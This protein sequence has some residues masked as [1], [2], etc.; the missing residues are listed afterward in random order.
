MDEK[1]HTLSNLIVTKEKGRNIFLFQLTDVLVWISKE[2]QEYNGISIAY[3]TCK[4]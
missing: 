3:N 1:E 4:A 2:V